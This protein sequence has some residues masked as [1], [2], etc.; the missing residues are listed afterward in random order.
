MVRTASRLLL[1]GI[2]LCA[3]IALGMYIPQH[4]FSVAPATVEDCWAAAQRQGEAPEGWSPPANIVR[5]DVLNITGAQRL[6]GQYIWYVER[7]PK[8]Q[9]AFKER[10][11]LYVRL[12]D[13]DELLRKALTHEFLHAVWQRRVMMDPAFAFHNPDSEVWVCQH[14]GCDLDP[15]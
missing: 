8:G 15:S 1:L 5:L 7:D 6:L 11:L 9:P 3:G 13:P 2:L 12:Q 14:H 10:V 4:E